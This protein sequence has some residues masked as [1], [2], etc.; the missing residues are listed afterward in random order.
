MDAIKRKMSKEIE[1]TKIEYNKSMCHMKH[2]IKL[3]EVEIKS[4]E[5]RNQLNPACV[6]CKKDSC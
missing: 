5:E 6:V 3:K 2:E 4:Y 1:S